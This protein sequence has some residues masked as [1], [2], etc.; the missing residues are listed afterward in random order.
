MGEPLIDFER[1]ANEL[2]RQ[3]RRVGIHGG[4]VRPIQDGHGVEVRAPLIHGNGGA[5]IVNKRRTPEFDEKA[6]PICTRCRMPRQIKIVIG[7]PNGDG[8][9]MQFCESCLVDR[10]DDQPL[11]VQFRS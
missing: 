5:L 11:V 10:P 7:F 8:D 1:R 2:I 3:G 9:P 6:Q 4:G